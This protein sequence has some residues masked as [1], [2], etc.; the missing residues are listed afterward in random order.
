MDKSDMKKLGI[1]IFVYRSNSN[2][3]HE[4]IEWYLFNGGLPGQAAY[5]QKVPIRSS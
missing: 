1:Q 4:W 3:D 2:H 5:I